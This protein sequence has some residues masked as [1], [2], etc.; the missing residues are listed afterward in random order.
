MTTG[1]RSMPSLRELQQSIQAYV[2]ARGPDAQTEV[3]ASPSVSA[4]T[5]LEI[6]ANA[7]CVRL[8]EALAGDFPALWA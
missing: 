8:Q 1:I 4:E 3:L 5:R 7:Y 2:L 6:Y